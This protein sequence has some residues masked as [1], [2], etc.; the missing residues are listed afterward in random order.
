MRTSAPTPAAVAQ[1]P[2]TTRWVAS[3]VPAPQATT[4]TSSLAVVRMSTSAPHARTP[5]TTAAPTLRGA[6]YVVALQGTTVLAKG[7][8]WK[9]TFKLAC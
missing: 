2:V 6:T 5:A 1:P 8:D 9:N 3:S 7:T 4:L